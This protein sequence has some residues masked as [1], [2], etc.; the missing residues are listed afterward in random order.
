LRAWH[1]INAN[2][3][4]DSTL[5]YRKTDVEPTSSTLW[6]GIDFRQDLDLTGSASKITGATIDPDDGYCLLDLKNIE[7][8]SERTISRL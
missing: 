4:D 3:V 5:D 8:M 2:V 6:V 7:V 1:T